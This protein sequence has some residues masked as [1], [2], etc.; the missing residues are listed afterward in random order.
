[1]GE[2]AP[3]PFVRAVAK[4]GRGG[5]KQSLNGVTADPLTNTVP[6]VVGT[7]FPAVLFHEGAKQGVQHQVVG[8]VRVSGQRACMSPQPGYLGLKQILEIGHRVI[9][10]TVETEERR[11][12]Q[13]IGTAPFVK[14][15]NPS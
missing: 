14:S 5:S 3:M 6:P 10:G 12:P 13:L 11:F 7:R 9:I 1:M 4:D 2:V 8:P 15:C